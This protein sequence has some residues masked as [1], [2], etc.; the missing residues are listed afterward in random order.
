MTN[1][2]LHEEIPVEA[3]GKLSDNLQDLIKK[4]L[5]RD[6]KKRLGVKE[7]GGFN[8]I[9]THPLFAQVDWKA[10]QDKKVVPPFVPDV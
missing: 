10:V 5:V 3:L 4:F 9:K 1:A 6:V 2:I 8:A 7:M